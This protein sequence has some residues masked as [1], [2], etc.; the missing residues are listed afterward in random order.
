[1]TQQ[2]SNRDR[3]FPVFVL[4]NFLRRLFSN[5]H[6]Y[7]RHV[8]P[9]GVVADLGSGPGFYTFPL[10]D[11]VGSYGKVFAVDSDAKAIH[12]VEKKA[13]RKHYQNIEAHT[14][15]AARLGFIEDDSV[16]F[17]LADGLICCMEPQDH[18]GTVAEIK[19]ILRHG[20]KAYIMTTTGSIS[21]VD[22]QEWE[23]ILSQF[24]VEERN[25]APYKLSRWAVV[26]KN[27]TG[28]EADTE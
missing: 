5:S 10:A 11:E 19:R 16:D 14:S 18:A 1:M 9:D 12:K 27:G 8:K 13:V 24:K 22:D 15:S 26:S 28:A 6:K 17:V 23:A 20:G 25:F 21:Y 7:D 2:K 4:D 3:H